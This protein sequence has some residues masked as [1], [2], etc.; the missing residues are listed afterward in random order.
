MR[1]ESNTIFNAFDL[2]LSRCKSV[3][4]FVSS[5][6]SIDHKSFAKQFQDSY[7]V[8]VIAWFAFSLPKLVRTIEKHLLRWTIPSHFAN[9]NIWI[10]TWY[11]GREMWINMT[12]TGT[13]FSVKC[14]VASKPAEIQSAS[15]SR[16]L[17]VCI[18]KLMVGIHTNKQY[19]SLVNGSTHFFLVDR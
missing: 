9:K 4:H 18:S 16:H 6:L 5:S 3:I 17:Y 10:N 19:I 7:V 1:Q 14:K 2:H 11:P 8:A 15:I 12:S 13:F